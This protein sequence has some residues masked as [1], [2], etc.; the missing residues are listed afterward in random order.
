MALADIQITGLTCSLVENG[1][2]GQNKCEWKTRPRKAVAPV[3]IRSGLP[4]K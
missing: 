1:Q 4:V 2:Y 3:Q